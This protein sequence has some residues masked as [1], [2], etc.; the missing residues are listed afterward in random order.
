MNYIYYL[1]II[2]GLLV[3]GSYFA[4][5]YTDEFIDKNAIYQAL[6]GGGYTHKKIKIYVFSLATII[7]SILFPVSLY[8][9]FMKKVV[10]K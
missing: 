3:I 1:Y 6:R 5:I 2:G 8:Y 7:G 9:I 10:K 4:M